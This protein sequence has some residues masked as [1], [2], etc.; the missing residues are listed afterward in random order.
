MAAVVLSTTVAFAQNSL[1]EVNES[2][3]AVLKKSA[4]FTHGVAQTT[5]PT[6]TTGL[7]SSGNFTPVFAGISNQATSY[8]YTGG[9]YIFGNNISGNQFKECA[10]GYLNINQ[11]T[12]GIEEVILFF[13][14]KTG[15]SN[16]PTSKAVV[17]VYTM[18]ADKA[19]NYDPNGT[20]M[21]S[22]NAPGPSV[23]KGSTD[24]LF[25]DMD[26][27]F[28]AFNIVSF[29]P[30]VFIDQTDFA[31]GF[32]FSD[33]KS[34]NDTIGLL[35]DSQGDAEE[36]DYAFLKP[37]NNQWYTADVLFSL[38]PNGN[39]TGVLDN[40]IALFAVIDENYV[41]IESP[42]F[43]NGMKLSQNN[44]NPVNGNTV[45]QYELEKFSTNVELEIFDVQGRKAVVVNE[46]D[47]SAGRH[48]ISVDDVK[49]SAGTYYY[50]L[51]ANGN[52]LTK[53]MVVVK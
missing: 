37:G 35:S 30:P 29:S 39:G 4:P 28:L 40:N 3:K 34:K 19:N 24:I 47:Q 51:K 42:E 53:K 2:G 26:T 6:D 17:K 43:F 41:G 49:L 31:I 38:P 13:A 44:P 20:N 5:T 11:A 52:R 36:L 7:T 33:L 18:A 16:D 48:S 8:G 21:L 50:S 10:Q 15:V 9:G 1:N 46:G 32:D 45:I 27:N 22:V 12:L 25:D 23:L 14:G